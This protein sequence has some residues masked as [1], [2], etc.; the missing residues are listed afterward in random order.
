MVLQLNY[1]ERLMID[2]KY[3]K[4][5]PLAYAPTFG[6]EGAACFDLYASIQNDT[7]VLAYSYDNVKFTVEA[8]NKSIY[9]PPGYRMLVPVNLIFDIPVG[10]SLR[11]HPRSGLSLKQ[12]LTLFNCTGVIDEDYVDPIF[13][14]IYN[15]SGMIQE[16]N[17]GDRLAQAN[18]QEKIPTRLVETGWKPEQKTSRNGGFG[19]TGVNNN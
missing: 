7:T 15:I 16:I 5:H 17:D 13:I 18:L 14:T 3:Y 19:S 10:Y 6:T 1:L 11:A 12:G 8:V 9:V 2:L 4:T